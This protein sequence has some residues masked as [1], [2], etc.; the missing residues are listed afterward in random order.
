VSNMCCSIVLGPLCNES[1]KGVAP[2]AKTSTVLC[3]F[4]WW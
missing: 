1:Y 3:Y 4:H 2:E